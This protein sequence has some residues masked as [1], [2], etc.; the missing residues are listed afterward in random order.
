MKQNLGTH[1]P[2]FVTIAALDG[3]IVAQMRHNCADGTQ[4]T[5]QLQS[6]ADNCPE[7]A[8]WHKQGVIIFDLRHC[9]N[10][11]DASNLLYNYRCYYFDTARLITDMRL[12]NI[13]QYH[14]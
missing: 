9:D 14:P 4:Q 6:M 3:L 8:Q 11:Q 12:S 10:W 13:P 7:L 5:L 2:L 1:K